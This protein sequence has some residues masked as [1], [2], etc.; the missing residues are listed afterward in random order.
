MK[1]STKVKAIKSGFLVIFA[2]LVG[3]NFVANAQT[4][5]TEGCE[6][7]QP[8]YTNNPYPHPYGGNQIKLYYGSY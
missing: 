7:W 4:P 5:P 1:L 2:L 8:N 3:L 6:V